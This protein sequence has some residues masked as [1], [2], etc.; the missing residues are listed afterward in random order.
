MTKKIYRICLAF[1]LLTGCT[2]KKE[3][4]P[5]EVY[6]GPLVQEE[7]MTDEEFDDCMAVGLSQAQA[8]MGSPVSEAFARLKTRSKNEREAK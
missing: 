5:Q 7:E 8:D 4:K 6:S 3:E 2:S 1:L